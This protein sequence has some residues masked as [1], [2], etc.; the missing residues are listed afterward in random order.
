M[1][2]AKFQSLIASNNKFMQG[3]RDKPN[4][5]RGDETD[6]IYCGQQTSIFK[7]IVAAYR[8]EDRAAVEAGELKLESWLKL[9]KTACIIGGD[10]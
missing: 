7:E 3:I 5:T 1:D 9:Y 4:R 10:K 8:A 2:L 6:L